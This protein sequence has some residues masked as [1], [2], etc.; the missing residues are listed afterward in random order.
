MLDWPTS[1][2]GDHKVDL[3][4]LTWGTLGT[5]NYHGRQLLRELIR[6]REQAGLQKLSRI[7]NGQLP[8]YHEMQAMLV[9]YGLEHEEC[10]LYFNLWEQA[11]KPGWWRECGLRDCSYVCMEQEASTMTEFQL[12]FLP[13][14]LQTE[15]KQSRGRPSGECP[16][17]TAA[18]ALRQKEAS[19]PTYAHPRTHSAPRSGRKQQLRLIERAKLPN[20]TL[21]VVPQSTGMHAGLV[22]SVILLD[23]DDPHEPDIAF[24]ETVLGVA[25]TQ[26]EARISNMRKVLLEV[27][28]MALSPEDSLDVIKPLARSES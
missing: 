25:H 2:L 9:A 20:V 18:K 17:A 22:G 15:R 7:G 11:K 28:A 24:T 10:T 19:G 21:Q 1:A 27:A 8:T 3:G 16:I 5:P 26:D 13:E 6:L 23:F 14:L 12:G 4:V